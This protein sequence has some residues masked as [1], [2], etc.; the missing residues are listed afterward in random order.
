M[1]STASTGFAQIVGAASGLAII[2]AVFG[3]L[4]LAALVAQRRTKEIGIRKAL[5]ATVT[6]IVGLLSWEFVKVVTVAFVI[7]APVAYF[8]MRQW[9]QDFAYHIELGPWVFLGAGVL[10]L[11]VALLAV[12]YQALRAATVN[13]VRALRTE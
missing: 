8:V 9:L 6:S 2:I 12:S 4:G 3:L 1:R 13:P 7:A 5:G 10:T 11:A